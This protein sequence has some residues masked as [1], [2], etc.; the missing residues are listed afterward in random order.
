MAT[1][2]ALPDNVFRLPEPG[3]VRIVD[4]LER[5]IPN[6]ECVMLGVNENADLRVFALALG[7]R[8]NAPK[9]AQLIN[10]RAFFLDGQVQVGDFIFVYTGAGQPNS[11]PLKSGKTGYIYYW[12]LERT[13]FANPN[14]VPVLLEIGGLVVGNSPLDKLLDSPQ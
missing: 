2:V 7:L 4:T 3:A 13:V 1:P 12:N 8:A 6:K 5:G 10:F 14:I 11:F 9:I